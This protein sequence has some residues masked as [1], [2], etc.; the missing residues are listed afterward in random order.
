MIEFEKKKK[1]KKKNKFNKIELHWRRDLS[2][3]QAVD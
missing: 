2:L 3:F 1:K